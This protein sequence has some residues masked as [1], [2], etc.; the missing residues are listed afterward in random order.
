MM[1]RKHFFKND[2]AVEMIPIRMLISIG[3][4]AA[5]S[6]L[7]AVGYQNISI[8]IAENQLKNDFNALQSQ[9]YLMVTSGVPR[10]VY[11][12][13]LG[14]GTKRIQTFI[15]PDSIQYLGFGCDPDPD[16]NGVV[17]SPS[18]LEDGAVFVFKVAG[19][20]KQVLWLPKDQ[21][22]FREGIYNTLFGRWDI[23][24]PDQGYMITSGGKTKIVCELV[25]RSDEM[26]VLIQATDNFS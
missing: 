4:I 9:L 24:T 1:L 26:F 20:S 13:G 17:D 21:I 16:N 5:I 8:S 18:L 3:V 11:D 2:T 23:N 10:D 6:V 14:E 19:G 12:T 15:V 25:K 22:R 7:I